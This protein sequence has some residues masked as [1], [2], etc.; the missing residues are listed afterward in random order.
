MTRPIFLWSNLILIGTILT[1]ASVLVGDPRGGYGFPLAWKTGGCPP[2]GIAITA[3]CLLAIGYDWLIFGLD[4]LVYT[5]VG[6]G[7][8]LAYSKYRVAKRIR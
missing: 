1:F 8:L 5:F 2:P 4:V 7:I 6:Y 3:T